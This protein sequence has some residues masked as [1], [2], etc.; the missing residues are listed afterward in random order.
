MILQ[1]E[2]P[3]SRRHDLP[4]DDALDVEAHLRRDDR[5]ELRRHLRLR[6]IV[7]RA[8]VALVLRLPTRLA[9]DPTDPDNFMLTA[10]F[11]RA[12][13]VRE[14]I[15]LWL[16]PGPRVLLTDLEGGS[17]KIAPAP[18]PPHASPPAPHNQTLELLMQCAYDNDGK[19][20]ATFAAHVAPPIPAAPRP[21]L[22]DAVPDADPD[23]RARRDEILD[24][25]D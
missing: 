16:G 17:R 7:Q 9:R 20:P 11:S 6:V 2:Q 14:G 22:S 18:N 4:S 19:L 8:G 12:T 1:I 15:R 5:I 24:Q 25:L 23:C 13:E 21:H 10:R 3:W